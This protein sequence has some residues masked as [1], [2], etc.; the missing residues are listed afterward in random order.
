M[1]A[2]ALALAVGGVPV[3]VSVIVGGTVIVSETVNVGV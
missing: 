1:E 3:T 2:V